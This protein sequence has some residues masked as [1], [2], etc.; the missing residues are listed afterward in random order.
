M[1]QTDR[2]TTDRIFVAS[3]VLIA[4]S[5]VMATLVTSSVSFIIGAIILCECGY[6]IAIGYKIVSNPVGKA[7]A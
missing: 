4:L 3:I 6:L 7:A 5:C 2:R 1:N